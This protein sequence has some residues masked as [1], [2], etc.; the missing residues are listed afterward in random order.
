MTI[1]K[2]HAD[3]MSLL[4]VTSA[5]VCSRLELQLELLEVNRFQLHKSSYRGS[6]I[7]DG[8]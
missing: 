7:T 3:Y 8:L 6:V 4:S 2:T 5:N 1:E